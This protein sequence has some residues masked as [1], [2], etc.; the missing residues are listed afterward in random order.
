MDTEYAR[1]EVECNN[2]VWTCIDNVP[3]CQL[4]WF[5]LEYRGVGVQVYLC[6]CSYGWNILVSH[7]VS[8]YDVWIPCKELGHIKRA[9]AVCWCKEAL[10]IV[11]VN[12]SKD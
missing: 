6:N 12:F 2:I 7:A 9:C 4:T 8:H 1:Y 5:D 11:A 3:S 10:D